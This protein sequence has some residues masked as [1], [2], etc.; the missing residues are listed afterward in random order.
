V[1]DSRRVVGRCSLL[2]RPSSPHKIATPCP[3]PR[4][5][6]RG[7]S[8]PRHPKMR[9][10]SRWG[11]SASGSPPLGRGKHRA[12]GVGGRR[13]RLSRAVLASDAQRPIAM[14]AMTRRRR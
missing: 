3:L 2:G 1:V 6:T 7:S 4:G 8:A 12:G 13:A 14:I 9:A 5:R 10:R 11:P